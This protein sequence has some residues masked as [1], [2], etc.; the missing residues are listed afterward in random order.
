MISHLEA[1][2]SSSLSLPPALCSEID[3]EVLLMRGKEKYANDELAYL[4]VLYTCKCTLPQNLI[5]VTHCMLQLELE[6]Q[7]KGL[8]EKLELAKLETCALQLKTE[9]FL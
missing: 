4:E 3:R 7:V 2:V 5:L 9:Y 1:I 8:K 6:L